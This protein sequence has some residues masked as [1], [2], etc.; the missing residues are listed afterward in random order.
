MVFRKKHYHCWY[1]Q[2]NRKG[3]PAELKNIEKRDER[4]TFYVQDKDDDLMLVSYVD[5][6][7]SWKKNAV[8]LTLMHDNTR[9]T[10]GERKKPQVHTFYDHTKGGVDIVSSILYCF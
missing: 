4:S 7:K 5:K 6:K 1:Q 3:I 10:K 2:L 9:V 8:V